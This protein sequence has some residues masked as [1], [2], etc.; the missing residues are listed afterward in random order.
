MGGWIVSVLQPMNYKT[1]IVIFIVYNKE[2]N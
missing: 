1:N 2:I